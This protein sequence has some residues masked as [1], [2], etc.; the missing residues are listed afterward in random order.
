M[1]GVREQHFLHGG[2][3]GEG[4][5]GDGGDAI[6]GEGDFRAFLV[7]EVEGGAEFVEDGDGDAGDG[8]GLRGDEIEDD[9]FI[10]AIF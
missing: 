10:A 6:K 7:G 4:A 9:D 8:G 2:A 5:L 3:G 1:L